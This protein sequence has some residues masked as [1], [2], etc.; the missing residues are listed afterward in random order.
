MKGCSVLKQ[1]GPVFKPVVSG[2]TN[3][4]RKWFLQ[5]GG[6]TIQKHDPYAHS[7]NFYLYN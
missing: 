1:K 7:S 4:N 6:D 5:G 3:V 2:V